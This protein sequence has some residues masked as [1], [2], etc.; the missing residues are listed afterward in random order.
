MKIV[1]PV[2]LLALAAFLGS[3]ASVGK[4][5]ESEAMDVLSLV[6][7]G[8]SEALVSHSKLPFVYGG[9]ILDSEAQLRLLWEGLRDEGFVPGE[10]V[11]KV[12][13]PLRPE[14][15]SLFSEYWEVRTWFDLVIKEEDRLAQINT[16]L[17][18]LSMILRP[19]KGRD[20]KI[21]AFREGK[22]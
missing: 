22:K 4:L 21:L 7:E 12:F 11:L 5:E 13:R 14:D 16:S 10:G 17:G 3:C 1:R 9:E 8:K 15:R 2:I 20:Y 6:N 18:E 19:V